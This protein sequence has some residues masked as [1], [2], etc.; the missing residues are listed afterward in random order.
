MKH[1]P[2]I[3]EAARQSDVHRQCDR[4]LEPEYSCLCI[5]P[6]LDEWKQPAVVW[7][8][9]RPIGQSSKI[10]RAKKHRYAK[11]CKEV[12]RLNRLHRGKV[13]HFLLPV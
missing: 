5:K 1:T 2:S 11:A 6:D 12:E 7:V 13:R 4:C 9:S 3:T 8:A 10:T